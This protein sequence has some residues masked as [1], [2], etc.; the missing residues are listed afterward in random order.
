[1]FC[2][3]C[4]C[5]NGDGAAF[6]RGC[7]APLEAPRN[8]EGPGAPYRPPVSP[9]PYEPV[10]PEGSVHPVLGAVKTMG[11]SAMVLVAIIAFS[12]AGLLSLI[13]VIQGAS[14]YLVAL[15]L[16]SELDIGINLS[17][18]GWR[19]ATTAIMVIGMIPT[20]LMILGMWM[21]YASAAN[22]R[23]PGMKTAGLT[24]IKVVVIIN[25]V[26]M[27]IV[28]GLLLLAC[29]IAM[30]AGSNMRYSGY[31]GYS[32]YSTMRTGETFL[33]IMTAVLVAVMVLAIVYYVKIVST[34]NT[35]KRTITTG[36]PSDR[37]SA[38]AAVMAII[39]GVFSAISVV[40]VIK[41]GVYTV[42]GVVGSLCSVVAAITFGAFLFTYRR[43]MRSLVAWGGTPAV[44]FGT[45]YSAPMEYGAP[46]GPGPYGQPG[47]G[48]Q[49]PMNPPA[50]GPVGQQTVVLPV[51]GQAPYV[52]CE[53]C[54]NQYDPSAGACPYCGHVRQQ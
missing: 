43:T 24:L 18:E 41:N 2:P 45:G 28:L 40:S 13:S 34:I 10:R 14:S 48:N 15:N 22:R 23:E 46:Q 54:R 47:P 29:I 17:V 31:Y 20:V 50:N 49:W 3:N 26:C 4:G 8:A 21:T 19:W 33:M 37:V 30:S 42:G 25:A 1:M 16:L 12:L 36:V 38:F 6:C 11:S 52:V 9:N 32:G 27:G 53:N 51:D 35:M 7:G 39:G 5:Q 44:P